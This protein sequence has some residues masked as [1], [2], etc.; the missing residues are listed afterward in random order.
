MVNLVV[1]LIACIFAQGV[2][3]RAAH[4][5]SFSNLPIGNVL[6]IHL[7]SGS[8]NQDSIHFNFRRKPQAMV[9]IDGVLSEE[10]GPQ[11]LPTLTLSDVDV[12]GLDNLL[13]FY[14]NLKNG[15][16]TTAD[17]ITITE[18]RGDSVVA[19]ETFID[20]S[21]SMCEANGML[22]LY[23]LLDRAT[24]MKEATPR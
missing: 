14:R 18:Y 10:K 12:D 3:R 7:Q 24:A 1:A 21:C 17:T 5:H 19:T 4:V 20:R 23:A 15:C 22:T 9:G 2:P 8:F 16:N 11:I 6:A 13:N